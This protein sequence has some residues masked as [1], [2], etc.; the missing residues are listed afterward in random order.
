MDLGTPSAPPIM[1]VGN[2]SSCFRTEVEEGKD[3]TRSERTRNESSV[4]GELGG[5]QD[6]VNC[7]TIES[8]ED[9]ETG[10]RSLLPYIKCE[11]L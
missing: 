10:A 9:I 7:S 4:S 11:E 6:G 5:F 2:G 1:D 3:H 8:L